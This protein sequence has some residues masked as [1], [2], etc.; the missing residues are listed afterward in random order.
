MSHA[1]T[2]LH[3]IIFISCSKPS[4]D[5]HHLSSSIHTLDHHSQGLRGPTLI[6]PPLPWTLPPREDPLRQHYL[7]PACSPLP[8]SQQLFPVPYAWIS[9]L[10]CFLLSFHPPSVTLEVTA[11]KTEPIPLQIISTPYCPPQHLG[12]HI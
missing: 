8:S 5:S 10:L 9:D 11:L 6:P 4:R 1:R 7:T 3:K 12:Y 2:R